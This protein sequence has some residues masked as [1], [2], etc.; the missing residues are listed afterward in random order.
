MYKVGICGHFGG[1]K[2][3]LDGQTVKTKIVT[4]E[5]M[6]AFGEDSVRTVDTYKWKRRPIS[7]L[8]KAFILMMRCKNI[9]IFPGK[10]GVK[11]FIPMFLLFN[12]FFRRRLHYVVIGGW[13]PELL[14]S[15]QKL[16][17]LITRYDGVY[18][19]TVSMHTKLNKLGLNNVIIMPNFKQID[20]LKESE[21][22][23][24]KQKPYRLCTFSRVSKEKGV[25]D[26]INSVIA[27]NKAFG[28]TVFSLDIYGQ[29][30][31]DYKVTFEEMIKHFPHYINYSGIVRQEDSVGVIKNYMALLFPTFYQGEG[32]AGTILD[33]RA[34]GVPVIASDWKY[35]S[36]IISNGYDGI[37]F[38]THNTRQLCKILTDIGKEPE[39]ITKLKKNCLKKAL[40]FLPNKVIR[41]LMAKLEGT[42]P[43]VKR[44]KVARI[45]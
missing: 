2:I 38:D 25:E 45:Q 32:F 26:A 14:E 34:S 36:E 8:Y 42:K 21:L 33:A 6:N 31:V 43:G 11:V 15:N 22:I 16:A 20:V 5:L 10:N 27:V 3:F 35:N 37:I 41:C 18:V 44:E 9:I 19:E 12:K 28:E 39:I 23:Y 29:L 40:E 1:N 13:L 24:P 7:L 4:K 30:D 17:C